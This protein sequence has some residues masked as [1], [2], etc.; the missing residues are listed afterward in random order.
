VWWWGWGG[1]WGVGWGGGGHVA[2][3]LGQGASATQSRNTLPAM[4]YA[5]QPHLQ[6]GMS[7]MT[8]PNVKA[9]TGFAMLFCGAL[10]V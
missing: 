5:G 6:A 10:R 8:K 9:G 3:Q 1:G 4:N 2:Q 7:Q